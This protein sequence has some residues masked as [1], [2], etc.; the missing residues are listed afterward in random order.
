MFSTTSKPIAKLSLIRLTALSES[1]KNERVLARSAIL[2]WTL[3][4]YN[5]LTDSYPMT[6]QMLNASCD[7][8]SAVW[9]CLQTSDAMRVTVNR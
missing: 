7:D 1:Y 3:S 6:V 5:V 2:H 9:M 8:V 4:D